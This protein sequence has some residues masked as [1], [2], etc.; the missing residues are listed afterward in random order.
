MVT[1]PKVACITRIPTFSAA[2]SRMGQ[3]TAPRGEAERA[4]ATARRSGRGRTPSVRDGDA[5]QRLPS[6]T[7]ALSQTSQRMQGRSNVS[8]KCSAM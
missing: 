8:P 6:A 7:Y 4:P 1:A 2:M 3:A 5:A